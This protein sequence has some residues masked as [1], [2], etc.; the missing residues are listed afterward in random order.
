MN[1]TEAEAE[2][3]LEGVQF[4]AAGL[5]GA[6]VL[7]AT[8]GAPLMFA[9]MN[10]EALRRTLTTGRMH[11]YSRS[12]G[13]L[14]LKGETSGHFQDVREVRLDCDGD[15]LV[16]RVEQTGG[17][18]HVGYRSCFFRR[19][20]SEGWSADGAKVFDPSRIYGAGAD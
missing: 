17:A 1:W 19:L 14:W 3:G 2:R 4:D 10:R 12:R 11:Y 6:I 20:A 7:D 13:R 8:D 16:F 15:A 18:C 9:W 5:V